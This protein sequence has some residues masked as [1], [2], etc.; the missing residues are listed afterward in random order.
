MTNVG[1]FN[2]RHTGKII[3][4]IFSFSLVIL[5]LLLVQSYIINGSIINI[6]LSLR[7]GF[8]LLIIIHSII[9]IYLGNQFDLAKYYSDRDPLTNIYNRRYALKALQ[10]LTKKTTKASVNLGLVVIDINNFKE[11]NDMYGH[12][13][14][15]KVLEDLSQTFV[16]SISDPEFVVRWGGDEFLLVFINKNKDTIQSILSE[17]NQNAIAISNNMNVEVNFSVG[18]SYYP[19][20]STDSIKLINI[21]DERMYNGKSKLIKL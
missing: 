16:S 3:G 10:K 21:A 20:D 9:G 8:F 19:E 14:G 15:D 7:V 18:I 1:G 5:N 2:L 6:Y 12:S 17:I 4:L 11:I 13:V